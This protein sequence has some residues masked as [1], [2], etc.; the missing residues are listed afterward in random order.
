VLAPVPP[1]A[2]D[3]TSET[4]DLGRPMRG[5]HVG[6]RLDNA[7]RSY[8]AVVDEW[9]R[10]LREDGAH[11]EVLLAGD[12]AGP[13]ADQTRSD[14]EEWSRLIEVRVIGLGN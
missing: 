9:S 10:L 5:V 3:A 7:W 11:V 8:F 2:A 1:D 12:R 4:F 14:I 6:L 13:G